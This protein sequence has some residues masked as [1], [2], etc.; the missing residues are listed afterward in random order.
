MFSTSLAALAVTGALTAGSLTATQP[1]WQTSYRV[2]LG[3]VAEQHKPL[4]VFIGRGQAG[5]TRL[6]T[7]GGLGADT[8]KLLKQGYVSLYLDVD[9][10]AGKQTAEAFQMTEGVV[11]SD[12][13]GGVMALRHEGTV[14]QVALTG[15][16]QQYQA[17][18][19]VVQTQYVVP[20]MYQPAYNPGPFPNRPVLNAI[21]SPVVNTLGAVRGMVMGGG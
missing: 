19:P 11:I 16:L 15:Y 6:V 20:M 3:Q 1:A 17:G 18:Q 10:A 8:A 2:A 5:Y 4:A 12:R 21:S 9:T 14:S 7:D 13:T